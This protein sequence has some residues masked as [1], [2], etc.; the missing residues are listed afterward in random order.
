MHTAAPAQAPVGQHAPP[1]RCPNHPS[2]MAPVPVP[3][4]PAPHRATPDGPITSP[5]DAP[6]S[7]ANRDALVKVVY[8]RLFDWLVG[9]IN[10]SIGQDPSAFASIGLLDIYGFESFTFNDLEQVRVV[11]GGGGGCGA[12]W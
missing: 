9:R 6:A 10:A 3:S 5:L 8:S 7:S 1:Q 12:C 4:A 2:Y 11:C